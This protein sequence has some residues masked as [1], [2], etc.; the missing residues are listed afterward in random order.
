MTP[1][2]SYLKSSRAACTA[3]SV[4][5]SI[6]VVNEI[7][8]RFFTGASSLYQ[9]SLY[10]F[11]VGM[12]LNIAHESPVSTLYIMTALNLVA[13]C[14][15]AVREKAEDTPTTPDF[16]VDMAESASDEHILMAND[17][18]VQE[19]QYALK[20]SEK[21]SVVLVGL[22]G[23]G[24]SALMAH[25]AALLKKGEIDASS[26]LYG[27]R[28]FFLDHNSFLSDT[29][30]V[31]EL[32][33]KIQKLLRFCKQ[34]PDIYIFIDELHLVLEAGKSSSNNNS[35]ADYLKVPI[36]K[37]EIR[38]IGASTPREYEKRTRKDPAFER[39]FQNITIRGPTPDECF[40]ML[41]HY[42][43]SLSFKK[44][45]PNVTF[46]Q[47][48]LKKIIKTTNLIRLDLG[49]PDKARTALADIAGRSDGQIDEQRIGQL[50][51]DY[52]SRNPELLRR[53]ILSD[54]K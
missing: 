8:S 34:N 53:P 1:I 22:P 35:V 43:E 11:T 19:L 39:R 51:K 25:V 21:S 48:A 18:R 4:V 33:G 31:G 49:Q 2:T 23:V 52:L 40:Q 14:I 46:T 50:L 37:G 16:L 13:L 6:Q 36:S 29:K 20:N 26:R 45:Y 32:N 9:I 15:R 28:I 24:K 12:I 41:Y 47:E 10:S 44:D 38:I 17:I 7:A 30:Y 5:L 3:A 42:S 27:K 54:Q